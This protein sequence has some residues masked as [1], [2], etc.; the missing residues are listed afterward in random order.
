[1]MHGLVN[2]GVE[3][4]LRDSFGPALWRDVAAD[5]QFGADSFDSMSRYDQGV[6]E[7][8]IDAAAQRLARSREQV[9]EDF[10][11]YLASHATVEPV[12]RLLRF[13][14]A[15]FMDFLLSVEDLHGR[16]RLAVPEIDVP[17]L[18]LSEDEPDVYLLACRSTFAGAGHVMAGLLRAMADDYGA[19]VFLEHRGQ[20]DGAEWLRVHVAAARFAAGRHFDLGQSAVA[21]GVA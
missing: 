6:T 9:L 15:D 3:C 8:L 18:A 7:A 20:Y 19:L 13:G 21:G 14:G 5:A 11:T 10:G 2:R 12:R 4:F 16:S 17:H 1:M